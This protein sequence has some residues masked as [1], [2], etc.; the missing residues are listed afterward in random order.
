[1]SFTSYF[2]KTLSKEVNKFKDRLPGQKLHT[3]HTSFKS[4]SFK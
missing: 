2:A 3:D 4:Q 1:M